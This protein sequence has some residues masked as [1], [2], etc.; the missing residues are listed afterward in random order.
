MAGPGYKGYTHKDLSREIGVSVTT[1]KSYRRKFPEFLLPQN[2]GKPIRFPEVSLDVCR[3]I[4]DGFA[5][6]L[7]IEE[8]RSS[9][10]FEFKEIATKSSLSISDDISGKNAPASSPEQ[11]ARLDKLASSTEILAANL[12]AALRLRG[13]DEVRLGRLEALMADILGLLNR[14]HSMH[15]QLLARLDS[16]ADSM[17]RATGAKASSAGLPG[18]AGTPAQRPPDA[19]MDLPVVMLSDKGDFLGITEK[20]GAPFSLLGFEQALIGRAAYLNRFQASWRSDGQD[21]VLVLGGDLGGREAHEHVFKK[22]TTHMGNLVV[23]FSALR[24]NGKPVSDAFLRALFKQ[25][26]DS[27]E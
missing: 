15:A 12:D 23:H 25:I 5:A 16:L 17:A 27:L 4:R 9:L 10:F 20:S 7:S 19:F 24:I 14:T 2:N 21:W 18:E 8:I 11:D 26:K 13:G 6:S 3:S 1:L 22:T